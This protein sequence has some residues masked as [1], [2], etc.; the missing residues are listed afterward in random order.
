MRKI[1]KKSTSKHNFCS[2]LLQETLGTR[3]YIPPLNYTFVGATGSLVVTATED[4]TVVNL[5]G[6]YDDLVLL[7]WEGDS[8]AR[9]LTDQQVRFV[10]AGK[11]KRNNIGMLE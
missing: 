9:N 11:P 3:Y 8:Y 1:K 4:S 2:M 10:S 7:E 5:F 6:D